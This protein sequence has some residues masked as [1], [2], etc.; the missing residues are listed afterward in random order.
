[1]KIVGTVLIILGIFMLIFRSFSFNQKEKVV[2]LGTV[3]IDKNVEKTIGWP[4]YAG[5]V[6]VVAGLVLIVADS[7]KAA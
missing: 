5:G 7:K 1:M 6:A 4:V 3:Q 2:D